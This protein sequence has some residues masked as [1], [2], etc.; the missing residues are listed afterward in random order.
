MTHITVEV[1]IK[2]PKHV[3]W[4]LISDIEGSPTTISGIDQ[5]EVLERPAVG[6]PG[7]KWKETRTL[8]GKSATE[9]MWITEAD[10]GSYYM[11]EARSH[12]S[13]YRTEVRVGE[14]PDG[15]VLRM[16]FA[17]EPTTVVAKILSV[18]L[19]WLIRR[20]VGKALRQD[21]EDVKRAAE[22]RATEPST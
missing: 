13:I 11:T 7:L 19:G 4:S 16:E 1:E 14:A 10:E 6:L 20:S 15:T 12:G 22:M 18:A 21:L 17:A 8:Y 5:V 9:T 3:V 2:A